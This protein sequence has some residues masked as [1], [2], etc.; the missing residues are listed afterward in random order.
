MAVLNEADTLD[1]EDVPTM[2]NEDENCSEG[3]SMEILD[4]GSDADICEESELTKF[5]QMLCDA[6]RKAMEEEKARGN[7]QKRKTYTGPSWTSLYHWKCKWVNLAAQ[8]YLPVHEFMK[9]MKLQKNAEE[10]TPPQDVT[11]EESEES[12]DSDDGVLVMV[13]WL[14]LGAS[15]GI[16]ISDCHGVAQGPEAIRKLSSVLKIAYFLLKCLKA[17]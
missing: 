7:K 11:I 3:S 9:W 8:G 5:S 1:S 12:S 6:Q 15:D 17:V 14:V 10:L 13:S 4:S 16:D 2:P